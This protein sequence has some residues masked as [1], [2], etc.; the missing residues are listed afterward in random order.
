MAELHLEYPYSLAELIL[1]RIFELGSRLARNGE[2]TMRAYLNG[3]MDLGK[4]RSICRVINSN[5]PAEVM[6]RAGRD[7]GV[8]SAIISDIEGK[9]A[10]I[11]ADVEASID[12]TEED[13]PFITPEEIRNRV[14]GI[15]SRLKELRKKTVSIPTALRLFIVGPSNSGKSSLFNLI[16][17]RDRSIVHDSHGTTRDIV[18]ATATFDGVSVTLCDTAGLMEYPDMITSRAL[19][20]LL[21]ELNT[22]SFLIFVCDA[23][24]AT[25]QA[26]RWL[27]SLP[28]APALYVANKTD[29]ADPAALMHIPAEYLKTS[30]KTLS[31]IGIL[32][33]AISKKVKGLYVQ[34]SW[35]ESHWDQYEIEALEGLDRKLGELAGLARTAGYDVLADCLRGASSLI[36]ELSGKSVSEESLNRIFSRFCIGK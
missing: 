16:L 27:P 22:R 13:I 17:G 32:K 21:R 14:F 3:R 20:C 1:S 15:R 35:F 19:D 28:C 33:E 25:E 11:L 34:Q 12:F 2:F 8:I 36:A 24:R 5:S 6:D 9:L 10:D 29:V 23:N 31:G 7:N 26:A 30:C 18:S 4:A